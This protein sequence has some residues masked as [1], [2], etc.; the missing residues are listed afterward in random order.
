MQVV[1]E[2]GVEVGGLVAAGVVVE[3]QGHTVE[4]FWKLE[5]PHLQKSHWNLMMRLNNWKNRNLQGTMLPTMWKTSRS[6]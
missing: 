2:D 3:V 5:Q 1:L 6:L 4:P